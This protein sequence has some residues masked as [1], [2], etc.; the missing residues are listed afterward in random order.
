MLDPDELQAE[1]DRDEP[2]TPQRLQAL[3]APIREH[4]DQVVPR[5][6]AG[7]MPWWRD[8][9]AVVSRRLNE[10]TGDADSE[11]DSNDE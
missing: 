8:H 7:V 9:A 11:T 1:L 2:L 6:V 10:L 4:T 5:G 3:R